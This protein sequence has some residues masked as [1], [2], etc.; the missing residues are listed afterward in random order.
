MV[1]NW[2]KDAKCRP[3]SVS[4]SNDAVYA[5][6]ALDNT[7]QRYL[8]KAFELASRQDFSLFAESHLS[9]ENA[10]RPEL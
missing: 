7:R 6:C 2:S 9:S 8:F 3:R 10:Q 4:F 1:S 5:L